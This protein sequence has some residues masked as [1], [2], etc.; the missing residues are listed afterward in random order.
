MVNEEVLD[1]VAEQD[2]D[3]MFRGKGCTFVATIAYME[4]FSLWFKFPNINEVLIGECGA[5]LR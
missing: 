1:D 3:K 2:T 4:G 5:S